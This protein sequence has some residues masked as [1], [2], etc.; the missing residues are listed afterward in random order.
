MDR[1]E[2]LTSASWIGV[3]AAAGTLLLG[4]AAYAKHRLA[5]KLVAES[6]PDLAIKAHRELQ[7][8]PIQA[9][10]EIRLWFHGPCANSVEFAHDVCSPSFAE[11]LAACETEELKELSLLNAFLGRVVSET[12]ILARVEVIHREIGRELDRSWM[13]C[14]EKIAGKWN[15]QLQPYGA[16]TPTDFVDRVEPLVHQ[17]MNDAVQ[18]ASAAGQQP[19][20][21]QVLGGIGESAMSLL[22]IVRLTNIAIPAFALIALRHLFTYVLSHLA[23]RTGDHG[24]AISDRVALLGYRLGS[25]FE[26]D[27]TSRIANLHAWQEHTIRS[28]AQAYASEAVGLV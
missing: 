1:R 27:I 19:A 13:E 2:F 28:A 6:L 10:E 16:T 8:L 20:F 22:P 3:G 21:S 9:C 23:D 7:Q 24:R 5:A 14:C 26:R 4:R 11:K 18:L 15:V 12:E 25:E 17:A